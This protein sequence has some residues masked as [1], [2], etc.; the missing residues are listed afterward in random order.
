M[1]KASMSLASL[2]AF[3]CCFKLAE[4]NEFNEFG[5]RLEHDGIFF[6]GKASGL[7][8]GD[9]IAQ[10][11]NGL[12]TRERE[13]LRYF[14]RFCEKFPGDRILRPKKTAG[15]QTEAVFGC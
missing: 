10:Q 2:A 12:L 14:A 1:P 5:L 11:P 6:P 7:R 8:S 4:T 3:L 9:R 15:P 13:D